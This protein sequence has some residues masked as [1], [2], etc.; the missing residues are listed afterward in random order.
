MKL[1]I[2]SPKVLTLVFSLVI[3]AVGVNSASACSTNVG[4]ASETRRVR[5]KVEDETGAVLP[6]VAVS[7]R[8]RNGKLVAATH[9]NGRGEFAVE[10]P[11]GPYAVDAELAGFV[12][13]TGQLLEVTSSAQPLR[14]AMQIPAIEQQIIITATKTE[15]PLSQIGNSVTVITGEQLSLEGIATVAEALRRV[16]GLHMVQ[17]GGPGQL[18]SLFVR[19]GE[20]DYTKVLIDG[21]AVNDPGGSYNFANL[22][23]TSIDR[24]EIIRGPQSAL[25]GSDAIAGVIQ[26]FTHPGTAEGYSP[27]PRAVAEGGTF[28]TTRYG[29]GVEGRGER[30]D[31]SASFSR[32]DT[33]N[34][35]Q[36]G[37]FNQ[38]TFAGNFGFRPSQDT[39]IRAIFR[40]E[41]GRAGV[42]GV[43][44]FH[45]PDPDEYF[46]RRDLAGGVTFTHF[47]T[48]SWTQRLSYTVND[49]RQLSVDP[50][51]S[52]SF[53][54]EFQGRR[55]PFPS[56]DFEFQFLNETRR[57][58]V[59][60]QSDIVLP[61]GHLLTAGADYER[62]SGTIGDPRFNPLR[63]L[64]NNFGAYIQD[65][66]AIG[67]RIFTAVGVRLED[68]E[69]FGFFAA[70]RVSLAIHA[71]Q[72]S[73][74]SPLGL[75]KIK[76]SFG[77]GIK[78]PTLVESFSTSPFFRGNPNLLPERSNSF[79]AGIE[80][81]FGAGLGVLEITYFENRFRNQIGFTTTN[82]T[83]FEGTFFNIGKTR[84]RG[85]ETVVHAELLHRWEISGG[86]TFL[87]SRVVES[88]S[89]FDPVFAKGQEL[90]R[91]PRHSGYADL[92][93]K[94]GSWTFGATGIFVGRRVDSDFS[95]LGITRNPGY[96]IVNFL[97]S[98]R[99][100][101]FSSFF[102]AVNN[103]FD[104]EY[105]E[106]L[107]FPALRRH[108]RIGLRF[109]L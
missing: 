64:R 37:S 85:V 40:G 2:R 67:N 17:S 63:A 104:E 79:D 51:D 31:Y 57:Q 83:T 99:L 106:V 53:V 32:F 7:I 44:A 70:P 48:I 76:G 16:A 6:R 38:S 56:F 62:E 71:H 24:I 34:N 98:C 65:Q 49:S 84:A 91:R 108:F 25:F 52:G 54:S 28:A 105:M 47:A 101:D 78:E 66:W 60:Y 21:I 23:A 36:N 92:R 10:L 69:N 5:G 88:T 102:A 72:P 14:L 20:S 15:A 93:W 59:N 96:G 90:F 100:S 45:R 35:V 86:Y 89:A 87:N 26:I 4:A 46:S 3:M 103:A 27:K 81:H 33:D 95:G 12:P 43:W 107:G 41:N 74:G 61:R 9:T 29:G 77:L 39:E 75:T 68:N 97:A 82:F 22:S 55:A 8:D 80:Q 42:P 30:A 94:P 18:A 58:K 13:L 73:A 11:E 1:S 19:G 109:G 50:A